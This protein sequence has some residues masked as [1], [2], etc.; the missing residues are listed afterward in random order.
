[1]SRF[2][3]LLVAVCCA[4]GVAQAQAPAGSTGECKDG[5][6]SSATSKR[7]ACAGHGGVKDWYASDKKESVTT[8]PKVETAAPAAA[9]KAATTAKSTTSGMPTT[10]AAGGGEGKVWVNT[11]TKVYHC[12]SDRWYGKTK[13]GE[14]MTE[15]EAK[16]HGMRAAAGKTCAEKAQ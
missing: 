5:T 12:Q 1:M 8:K 4:Y 15:A 7:G 14:Y 2:L 13:K 16:S 6:Y 9:T 10:A 11:S 3:V